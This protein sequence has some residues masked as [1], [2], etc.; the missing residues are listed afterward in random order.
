MTTLAQSAGATKLADLLGVDLREKPKSKRPT[1]P[2]LAVPCRCLA[3]DGRHDARVWATAPGLCEKCGRWLASSIGEAEARRDLPGLAALAEAVEDVQE[4]LLD[5]AS[6]DGVLDED[7]YIHWLE[8]RLAATERD[9]ERLVA[10][11]KR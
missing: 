2:L 4:G 9:L 1:S 7:D 8:T 5:E 11:A 10:G 6:A 3:P